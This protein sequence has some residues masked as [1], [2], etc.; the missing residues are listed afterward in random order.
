M[1]KVLFISD[2]KDARFTFPFDYV[3]ENAVIRSDKHLVPGHDQ[4]RTPGRTDTRI[5]N[6]QV[7]CLRRK[8]SVRS[9]QS[10]SAGINIV[11]RYLMCDVNEIYVWISGKDA[12]LHRRDKII[13]RAE[14]SQKSDK[15]KRLTRRSG[16]TE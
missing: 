14:V 3:T 2:M 13:S 6:C 12:T 9:Q 15:R 5:D 11:R 16:D 7:N 1:A 8:G 4:N 10:E